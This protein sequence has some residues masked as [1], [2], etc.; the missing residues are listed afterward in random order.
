MAVEVGEGLPEEEALVE[1]EVEVEV[2]EEEEEE[3]EVAAAVNLL[4]QAQN[5][6]IFLLQIF[7]LAYLLMA[8]G[9][10]LHI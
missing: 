2:E 10:C 8:E 4:G 7:Q 3:E 6:I 9:Y 5:G 1:V